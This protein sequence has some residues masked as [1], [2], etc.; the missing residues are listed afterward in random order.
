MK[1]TLTITLHLDQMGQTDA[2]R[3]AA[4]EHELEDM[5]FFIRNRVDLA[6]GA[7]IS[8][9]FQRGDDSVGHWTI[10]NEE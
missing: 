10:T 5:L 4:I 8:R 6:N 1:T 9:K 2:A 3:Y 7:D